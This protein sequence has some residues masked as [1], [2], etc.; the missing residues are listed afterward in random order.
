MPNPRRVERET[1]ACFATV[2]T[3]LEAVAADEITRDLGGDV[4]KADKGIVVFRVPEIGPH[5]L[6]LRTADDVFLLAW[7]TDSLTYKADDL[8]SIRQWT[9]KEADWQHLLA[10]HHAIRPKPKGKPT[11]RLVTQM[12]GT[13]GYRRMD[14]GKAMAQGLGG[15]F[16]PS[17]KPAEENAAVEVWLIIRGRT[18]VCGVRL[19]DKTMRHRTYKMEHQPASLRPT[20]A[21]AMVRLA[22]AAPGEVVLDPMCGAGTILAEQIELS[23]VRKAGRVE[24]WGG[25][26]DMNMLRAAASNL[27]KV[28]PA[29]LVHWDATRL[30]LA[31]ESVDR[32]VCNPPFGKQLSSPEEIG[33]LYRAA[34]RESHRVLKPGGRAV[35][36]VSEPDALRDAVKPHRWQP[37]RQLQVEV[38]GQPATISVWQKP[39]GHGTVTGNE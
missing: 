22:G 32:I 33:P 16:P 36:L 25:D 20:I 30:P 28:G 4:K 13:H 7:G 21:A 29:L 10:L 26:L 18:A 19:S 5:L 1:P 24:T 15:V 31:R 17:W 3:G 12:G 9:A 23:K 37:S 27:H 38:L 8:K 39:S 2:P 34:I 35:F 6:R 11:Y 14:A